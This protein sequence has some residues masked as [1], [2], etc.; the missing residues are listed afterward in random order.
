MVGH[1]I[2]VIG[3]SAGG[4][5]ALPRLI[6]SLPADLAASVFVVL[7]IPAQGQG[8]L[9]GIIR[10]SASLSVANGVD[11]ETIRK[12]HV[13]VAPPDH[14]LQLDGARVRLSR[15]PRE[16]FHRPSIDALF[17]TAAESYGPRVVGV[18][19][20][21]YLDDGTAGL[22]AVK[23]L[24]GIAVVQDP[25]DATAPAMPQSA[26]R[27]IK[28]D[29][30]LPLSKIGPLLVRLATTRD[31]P[32]RRTGVSR[33]KKRSLSPTEME[34][35]F[36]LPTSF[37]CPECNGPLWET[38]G[39]ASLQFRCHVGHAYSP[40]SLLADHADGL[41]RALW[42]AVRTFDERAVLLRRLEERKYHSES[43]GTNAAAKAKELERHA[44]VI[45]KLLQTTQRD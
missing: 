37:V 24:G 25:T 35:E 21:G 4:V 34:Q 28:T 22:H 5:D 30:C 7:H 9:P 23:R 29:H 13:Y 3:A 17:R 11:G 33:M 43:V 31:I 38:Q 40:D 1:N 18:V 20:T 12:G 44:D 8:L 16:N 39:G 6:G 26:L 42:S 15:G 10:K 41:E 19:L 14:H 2:I 27:N 32:T 45:R 36:G